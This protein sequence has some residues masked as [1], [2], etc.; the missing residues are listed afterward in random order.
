DVLLASIEGGDATGC[1]SLD[2]PVLR[3]VAVDQSPLGN[4]PRSN[5]ATYTKV[6]DRI[7]NT[8][9]RATRKPASLFTFNRPEGACAACEGMGAVE[10]RLRFL[11][12]AWVECESCAGSRYNADA[13]AA[14]LDG[15]SI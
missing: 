10:V 4:N 5:P 13:I 9:A 14:T 6:F 7:R 11:Y 1:D 3:A 2:G 12:P 15:M 8:F